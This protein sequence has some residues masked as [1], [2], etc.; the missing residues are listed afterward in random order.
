MTLPTINLNSTESIEQLKNVGGCFI[1]IPEEI[2]QNFQLIKKTSDMFFALPLEEKLKEPKTPDNYDGY[3]NQSASGYDIERYINSGGAP[4]NE[5][6]S[7]VNEAIQITRA[8]LKNDIL[9]KAL[10]A[11][12]NSLKIPAEKYQHCFTNYNNTLSIIHYLP[13]D[14]QPD[15]LPAH[16]DA[17]LLTVL[18][19]PAPGLEAF[20]NDEWIATQT[21]PGHVILQIGD[22]L[23]EWTDHNVKPLLHRVIVEPNKPRTSIASF[24]TLD[25]EAPFNNLMTDKEISPTNLDYIKAHLQQT[26]KPRA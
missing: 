2:E 14:T 13:Q 1:A 19:A 10:T 11:I 16:A 20:V 4:E 18:W 8:Y 17:A 3:L 12:L 22:G 25:N 6:M 21:P 9:Q 26:Y 5:I 23:A 7:A 15:R 24:C